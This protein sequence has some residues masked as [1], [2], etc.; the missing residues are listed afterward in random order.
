M[1]YLIKKTDYSTKDLTPI[2]E[3]GETVHDT[4]IHFG[5]LKLAEGESYKINNEYES[6]CLLMNGKVRFKYEG[7]Q[8]EAK[9]ASLIEEDPIAIHFSKDV[10]V[11][12]EAITDSELSLSQ[13]ENDQAFPTRVFDSSNM[14][15]SE[16]RGKGKLNDAAYRI[17]RTIFDI[18]N[19]PEAKLV[20]GEVVNFSGRWSSY[21]PHHHP[22][23]EIY[24][25]RFSP[26]QGYG[27]GEV[28][29]HVY[30]I[31][32]GDTL[33]ILDNKDHAQVAA[34]GYQMYYTWII[35]HLEG[36]PYTVPEF[37]ETHK[38]TME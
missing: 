4:G 32:H 12:V 18:R 17:V 22:Q 19:R 36:N 28:G 31:N 1:S 14:L 37:T 2:T 21:P 25:Y 30:K 29:E 26:E 5:I 11:I 24:H 23:P 7:N 16:H 8:Y 33:K 35:R 10:Q 15:E 27:H 9:R 6:A 38:W 20:L 34:P 3:I 13:V